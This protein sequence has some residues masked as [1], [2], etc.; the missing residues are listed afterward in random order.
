MFVLPLDRTSDFIGRLDLALK[1][2]TRSGEPTQKLIR[3]FRK[4]CEKEGLIRD[5]RRNERYE[6]PSVRRRRRLRKAQRAAG[7]NKG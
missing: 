3:R 2:R 5:M 7:T 1:V 6:K 4:L